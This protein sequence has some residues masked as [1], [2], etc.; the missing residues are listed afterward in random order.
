MSPT[1]FLPGVSGLQEQN[2]FSEMDI[3]NNH[4]V[5]ESELKTYF[6]DRGHNT[7]SGLFLS[8]DK[9]SDNIISYDEFS[10]PKGTTV[11][12]KEA[13]EKRRVESGPSSNTQPAQSNV[14]VILDTDENGLISKTE[15][16]AQL[17]DENL[18]TQEDVNQDG[19]ISWQEFSGPKG[20]NPPTPRRTASNKAAR[21]SDDT[22]QD[23]FTV[24]D[25]NKD[26][27]LTWPEFISVSTDHAEA[28]ALFDGDDINGDG[29]I[30]WGEFSGPKVGAESASQGERN[31]HATSRTPQEGQVNVFAVLDADNNGV[32]TR[33]EFFNTLED[34]PDNE[35]LF[36]KEDKNSDGNI[37]WNEFDGPK[38][39][40]PPAVTDSSNQISRRT[41]DDNEDPKYASVFDEQD[42]STEQ[43]YLREADRLTKKRLLQGQ[44]IFERRVI[45]AEEE[46]DFE[47]A[48]KAM[49]ILQRILNGEDYLGAY[50]TREMSI[51]TV[52]DQDADGIITLAEMEHN[53]HSNGRPYFEGKFE[54]VDLNGD[55]VVPWA[56]FPGDK[57]NAP[58][59][60]IE[61]IDRKARNGSLAPRWMTQQWLLERIAMADRGPKGGLA[62]KQRAQMVELLSYH[63]EPP[64]ALHLQTPTQ[65]RTNAQ[66]WRNKDKPDEAI[67]CLPSFVLIGTARSA[68]TTTFDVLKKHPKLLLWESF[69]EKELNYWNQEA[70]GARDYA[71]KLPP[72]P[73]GI[74]AITGEGSVRYFLHP[75]V[76]RRLFEAAPNSKFIVT[77]RNPVFRML[78]HWKLEYYLMQQR[79]PRDS[80]EQVVKEQLYLRRHSYAAAG[81]TACVKAADA[82]ANPELCYP[83]MSEQFDPNSETMSPLVNYVAWSIYSHQFYRWL[84]YFPLERFLFVK[85]EHM[86]TPEDI[87]HNFNRMV[88]HIGL[89]PVNALSESGGVGISNVN[90]HGT[91][92]K[93][94]KHTLKT[95][96]DFFEPLN[97]EFYEMTGIDFGWEAEIDKILSGK[98]EY[99]GATPSLH[100][101]Q[102]K[103]GQTTRDTRHETECEANGN[104]LAAPSP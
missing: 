40:S 94:P 47:S 34:N 54:T 48:A 75:Q 77:V 18:W 39:T 35:Q 88:N 95:L 27:R 8:E 38:G 67:S 33:Q 87:Q 98:D 100:V 24:I 53:F 101:A 63:Q 51:F 76:P 57:G 91:R 102:P 30:E 25:Q 9:D 26:G 78:S 14:F 12:G 50:D 43:S 64:N 96:R 42:R 89:K 37:E 46:G 62:Q 16:F 103:I 93:M 85:F 32:V 60:K 10:G 6:Q 36:A 80:F 11:K 5:D 2:L 13:V 73:V 83:D 99:K 74:D 19:S 79:D 29:V 58:P 28:R 56:E 41:L 31:D 70:I 17:Q 45:E 92:Y 7:P 1:T 65:K 66:C 90:P 23:L 21:S 71:E 59:P 44:D 69:D 61:I 82:N 84:Q 3:D 104:C 72:I 52:L 20:E 49:G 97:R 55:G 81:G 15:F 22:P 4:G 68:S 86:K